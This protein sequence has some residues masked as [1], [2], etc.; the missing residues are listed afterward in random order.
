[1]TAAPPRVRVWR[2]A[3]IPDPVRLARQRQ[4][5]EL[6]ARLLFFSGGT[7]LRGASQ[8]L[9]EYTHNSIHLITPFD[10]GGSSA[11]LRKAFRMPAVGDLRNRLMALADRSVLGHPEIYSLFAF[12]FPQ[13]GDPAELRAWLAEMVTGEDERVRAVRQPLRSLVC[14]YLALLA[15]EMPATFDLRGANIGNLVLTG[16]YLNQGRQLDSVLFLFSQLVEARGIVRPIVDDDLHLV[17]TLA[18]GKKIVGQHRLTG[19]EVAPLGSSVESLFLSRTERRPRAYRPAITDTVRELIASADLVCY[20]IGSFYTSLIATLLPQGVS[21]AVA[22]LQVPKVFVPNAG[23]DP[24]ELGLGP[25]DKVRMLLKYLRAGSRLPTG[26]LLDFVLMDTERTGV[27]RAQV[28]E[29]ERMGVQVLDTQL[30]SA[31]SAPYYDDALFIE[32][33]LSLV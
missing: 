33:L 30:V 17:A 6:G 14:N 29:I 3:R 23:H 16:G 15:A 24:E 2:S 25:A 1:M 8:R 5:P 21:D 12:R 32:A 22:D 28:Q 31:T 20:P 7:A 19:H 18:D 10:S 13:D 9:I 26:A 27:R 11:S 4:A